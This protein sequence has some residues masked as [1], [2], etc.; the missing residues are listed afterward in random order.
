MNRLGRSELDHGRQRTIAESLERISAVTA[1]EVDEVAR[2]LLSAPLTVAVI[3][4]YDDEED[5]PGTV[6]DP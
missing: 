5:L 1:E 3:G 6:R 4:P 2:E